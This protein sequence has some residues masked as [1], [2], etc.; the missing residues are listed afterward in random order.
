LL[1]LPDYACPLVTRELVYTAVSR[2]RAAVVVCG[3]LAAGIA[4]RA[5]RASGIA[6]RLAAARGAA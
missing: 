4:T 3:N 2:A 6:A 1:L 5:E